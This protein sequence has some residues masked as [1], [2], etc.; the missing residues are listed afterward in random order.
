MFTRSLVTAILLLAVISCERDLPTQ[1]AATP[2]GPQPASDIVG[3]YQLT[4]EA[5][6]S[7]SLAADLM[8][9]TYKANVRAWVNYPNVAVDVWGAR[10]FQ[11]WATGFGGT[12]NGNTVQ[13][14]IVGLGNDLFGPNLAELIDG[15]K[16]LTY[17]GT[18]VA[19]IRGNDISSGAFDGQIAL[20][21]DATRAVLAECRATDHQI[22]FVR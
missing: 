3:D 6:P 8:K 4:F 12:R 9:R 11:D 10:F 1:P 2:R 16:W 19:T 20:R 18:A 13:F 17:D 7:C 14:T 5:S 21:D 15:T 22:E